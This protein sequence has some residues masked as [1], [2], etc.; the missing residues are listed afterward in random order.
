M[1]TLQVRC[2][3]TGR[4]NRYSNQHLLGVSAQRAAELV[5][6][7]YAAMCVALDYLEVRD[8][9][10]QDDDGPPILVTDWQGRPCLTYVISE[11]AVAC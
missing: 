6:A 5:A 7:D 3:R 10:D 11:E 9:T 2:H 1:A 4:T 8:I